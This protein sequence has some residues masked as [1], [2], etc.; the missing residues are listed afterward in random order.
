[1]H[2]ALEKR[3]EIGVVLQGGGALG[4]YECGGMAALLELMDE[5][6]AAGCC[7][8]LRAVSGVSIGAINAACVVG[9][10]D[11]KDAKRRLNGLW[12]DLTLHA[13]EFWPKQAQR[14]LSLFGLPGF[15]LPR[16]DLVGFG[17]WTAYY[18]TRPL[19]NTLKRHVDFAAINRSDTTFVITAV[20]VE[21]GE[22]KRFCNRRLGSDEPC[23][24]TPKHV[25]AS[26]S[27]P[28]QFPWT[29]IGQQLYWDGGLVDNAPLGDAIDAFSSDDSVERILVVLNL[30]PLRARKPRSLADV[31]DRMH[32]LSFGNHVRQDRRAAERVNDMIETIEQLAALVPPGAVGADLQLRIDR[33]RRCKSIRIVDIDVQGV[34]NP[35]E[36]PGDQHAEDGQFGLRDFSRAAVRRRRDDGYRI[37]RTCLAPIFAGLGPASQ[38]QLQ[39]H[40]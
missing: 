33:A 8:T 5:A 32:E 39:T 21:S 24:I 7:P 36:A 40:H 30:Y 17:T 22:L 37:A 19:L 31:E 25:L 27:L 23:H 11:R 28:P 34:S 1:M 20:N 2:G 10:R 29:E 18:N 13:P 15:Y 3:V 6:E 35:A 4:A 9:A 14:D 38:R 26:G 12:D 16:F